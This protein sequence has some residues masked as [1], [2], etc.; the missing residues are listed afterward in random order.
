MRKS[1]LIS[2]TAILALLAATG[3]KPT[4]SSYREAYNKAAVRDTARTE[5]ENTI[6]GRYRQQV[7]TEAVISGND[8]LQA[9][10]VRVYPTTEAGTR[11]EQIKRWCV[12]AADFKQLFNAR[13]M[14]Q[15]LAE[16]GFPGAFVVQIPEPYYYVVAASYD[17][18]AEALRTLRQLET[19]SPVR[20]R[21]GFPYML[22]PAQIR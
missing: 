3:C 19:A 18:Y 12:V 20:L 7:R 5:F 16:N 8:T 4:E 13:S 22:H 9:R 21:Q 10:T 15:R 2:F 6:Y 17:N 14:Q 11:P 1:V